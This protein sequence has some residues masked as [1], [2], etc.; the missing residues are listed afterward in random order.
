MK[1]RGF[2][3]IV[4]LILVVGLVFIAKSIREE[5]YPL[6][7]APSDQW[8]PYVNALDA[9][10][11][12]FFVDSDGTKL[13]AELFIPNGGNDKKPA[14]VFVAGSGDSL[15]QNYGYGLVETYILDVFSS[16]DIAVLLIN[17]RGMGL[18][19]GNYVKNSIE[20]RAADIFAAVESIMTHPNI[21]AGNIGLIGHSQGGWVVSLVAA[22]HPEIAFFISLV[23]PTTTVEENSSDNAYHFGLCQGL[24]GEELDKYIEKRLKLVHFSVRLGELTNFGM[25]G[26]DSRILGYDPRNALKAV[27]SPGLFVYA[28]NDDQ[29]TPSVSID[30]MNEIFNN[31]IPEHFSVVVIDDASHAFRLVNDPCQSWVNPEEQEQSKQLTEVLN[32]WLEAQGY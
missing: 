27:Q 22:E 9:R 19:E 7:I 8:E 4:G 14:V 10:R 15:Y 21:D 29:V 18:S 25:F 16:H 12:A 13:E 26:L 3:S 32:T 5:H 31:N 24:Q 20:G 23:G 11:E 1:K 6:P 30:R 2:F 28:E 17:K